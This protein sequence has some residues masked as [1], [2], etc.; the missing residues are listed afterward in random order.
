MTGQHRD[1]VPTER[2]QLDYELADE[3]EIDGTV[4]F[5]ALADPTRT[6]VLSMLLERAATT[7]QLAAAMGKPKGTV[8]YHVK[9][10]EDSGLIRVVRTQPKRA[11]IEK[12]YGRCGR[13]I[14]IGGTNPEGID[15]LF[16][17]KDAVRH[18]AS[19]EG[20]A[21]PMFTV[22]TARIPQARAVEFAERLVAL[23]H[24][25]VEQPRSGDR[26]YGFVAGVYPT[27]LPTL[28]RE[29]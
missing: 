16:M 14:V 8:G 26:V 21:L 9:A 28:D 13:T 18:A 6:A 12:Y 29:S 2:H 23:A 17:L 25:Y 10:L 27:T 3:V 22:R 7:S 5:K 15:P 4:A 11:M 20:D 1:N 19:V 24:E